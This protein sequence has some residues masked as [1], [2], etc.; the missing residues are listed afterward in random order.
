MSE[1]NWIEFKSESKSYFITAN[2]EA[3]AETPD[4]IA[5]RFLRMNRFLERDLPRLQPLDLRPEAS[6]EARGGP[7]SLRR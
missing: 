2:W 4:E 3:R 6:R 7:R 5:A 1:P